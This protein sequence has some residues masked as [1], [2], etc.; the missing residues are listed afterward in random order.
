VFIAKDGKRKLGL[1][2]EGKKNCWFNSDEAMKIEQGTVDLKNI[3]ENYENW[4]KTKE[5]PR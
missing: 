5:F 2:E 3:F 4:L 1:W